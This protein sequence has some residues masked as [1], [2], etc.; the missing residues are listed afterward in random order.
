[1][2]ELFETITPANEKWYCL[3][4]LSNEVW[5]P[6]NGYIFMFEGEYDDK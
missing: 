5:K 2:K 4:N 6:I 3:E 1:M